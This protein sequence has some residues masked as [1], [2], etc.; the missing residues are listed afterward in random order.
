VGGGGCTPGCF[1][2]ECANKGLIFLRVKKSE[3]R[4]GEVIEKNEVDVSLF[5]DLFAERVKR[6]ME[7]ERSEQTRVCHPRCF[8]GKS[9]EAIE[10]KGDDESVEGKSA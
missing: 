6:V 4:Q 9:A 3:G 8:W 2:E 1:C 5:F 10:K 7:Q